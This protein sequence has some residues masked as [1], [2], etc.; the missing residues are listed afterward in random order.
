MSEEGVVEEGSDGIG[1]G[2]ER[3]AGQAV[4]FALRGCGGVLYN[5]IKYN[6]II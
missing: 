3:M 1:Q 2:G 6:N 5:D 4:L